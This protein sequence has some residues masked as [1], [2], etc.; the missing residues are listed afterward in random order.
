[1]RTQRQERIEELATY[2]FWVVLRVAGLVLFFTTKSS[3]PHVRA[4]AAARAI[5]VL[6]VTCPG[7]LLIAHPTAMVAAFAAAARLGI[8]IK[9]TRTLESAANIDTVVMDKTGTITT[10]KFAVSRLAPAEGVDG[11]ALLQAAADGEQ[12]SNHPLAKSILDTATKARITPSIIEDYEEF[13]GRGVVAHA[14][15]S[16]GGDIH[17][18][19]AAWL[20]EVNPSVRDQV[21]AVE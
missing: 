3:D 2:Y 5:S 18:G 1:G 6:V 11:A 14:P 20:M 8:M 19:R 12:H 16:R 4:D 17:V 9:Q 21:A 13:H 7:A 15:A 10:G